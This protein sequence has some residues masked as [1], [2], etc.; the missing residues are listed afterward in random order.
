MDF[1][2][3]LNSIFSRESTTDY[4]GKRGISWHSFYAIYYLFDET[5]NDAMMHCPYLD[6][7]LSDRNKQETYC[8]LSLLEAAFDK[9]IQDLPFIE[10]VVLKSDNAQLMK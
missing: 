10:S 8:V 5:L 9:I 3:K 4:Y 1:N 6:R 7:I 2:M